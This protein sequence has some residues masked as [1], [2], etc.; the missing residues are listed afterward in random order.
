MCS[1]S[2]F[3]EWTFKDTVHCSAVGWG[4]SCQSWPSPDRWPTAWPP[5]WMRRSSPS[6]SV[7]LWRW[8]RSSGRLPRSQCTSAALQSAGHTAPNRCPR[9]W[10]RKRFFIITHFRVLT[11]LTD[12]ILNLLWIQLRFTRNMLADWGEKHLNSEWFTTKQQP[13]VKETH[14]F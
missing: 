5:L 14:F 10:L 2:R 9:D 6:S 13:E 7:D 12:C 3:E 4:C 1:E 11:D 8:W